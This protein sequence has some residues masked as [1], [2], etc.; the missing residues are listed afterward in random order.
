MQVP[1]ALPPPHIIFCNNPKRGGSQEPRPLGTL[2]PTATEATLLCPVLA[3]LW[4]WLWGP[5]ILLGG[6]G[7][8]LFG[9]TQRTI[10]L[11]KLIP[12]PKLQAPSGGLK[13]L[14]GVR[15]GPQDNHLPLCSGGS[16]PHSPPSSAQTR[17]WGTGASV[18]SKEKAFGT[19]PTV[20]TFLNPTPHPSHTL[21]LS[22]GP[23]RAQSSPE[24][25]TL[26]WWSQKPSQGASLSPRPRTAAEV[27]AVRSR[28]WYREVG[29]AGRDGEARYVYGMAS[30]VQAKRG[31][32]G[33]P[34]RG[35]KRNEERQG[36]A[37]RAGRPHT[38]PQM[39]V[40]TT[41]VFSKW[42][43]ALQFLA[44]RL[45]IRLRVARRRSR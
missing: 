3:W 40:S 45:L 35:R 19:F 5:A 9:S 17:G 44:P 20:Q 32:G 15:G 29:G 36:G 28:L 26:R 22:P 8:S 2:R 42:R 37:G 34:E 16:I 30:K 12:T 43:M 13:A 14:T 38:A 10:V 6:P 39:S 18:P 31:E 33:R 4:L 1:G 41:K 7:S 21:S 27:R 24:D 25:P 23:P 11:D